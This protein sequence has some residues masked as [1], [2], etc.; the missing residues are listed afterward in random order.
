MLICR[1]S[2]KF[3]WSIFAV[4]THQSLFFLN[5]SVEPCAFCLLVAGIETQ[6]FICNSKFVSMVSLPAAKRQGDR[7]LVGIIGKI[8]CNFNVFK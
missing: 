1:I 4:S 8:H 3:Q 5:A 7:W 6:E 2:E